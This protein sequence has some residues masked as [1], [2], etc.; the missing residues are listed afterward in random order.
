MDEGAAG[1]ARKAAATLAGEYG[2]A[3]P[4]LVERQLCDPDA[5]P[6]RFTGV[7]T[8]IAV[9]GLLISL[10]QLAWQIYRDRKQDA[11]AAKAAA[12]PP[13]PAPTPDALARTLRLRIEVPAGL[14]AA[15]R[16]RMIAVIVEDGTTTNR[17][18]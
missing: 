6:E 4:A 9:A 16:D 7:E 18:D 2:P 5:P 3:L 15:D 10:A 17:G 11:A 8:A 14:T 1:L 13:P 12:A